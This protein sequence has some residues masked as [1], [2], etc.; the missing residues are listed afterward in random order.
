MDYGKATE[1]LFFRVYEGTIQEEV[2]LFDQLDMN[3]R[4]DNDT[5]LP[6]MMIGVPIV[7][8][9]TTVRNDF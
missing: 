7:S 8:V 9:D 4:I 5:G 2:L 1:N 3:S 6:E